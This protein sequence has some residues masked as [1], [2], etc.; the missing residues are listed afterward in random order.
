MN[1]QEKYKAGELVGRG[2]EWTDFTWNPI[3]GCKHACRWQMPDGKIAVCYAEE[4]AHGIAQSHYPDGFEAHYYHPKRLAEPLSLREPSKIFL[5]SMADLMGHW[6]P[7][8]QVRAVLDFC[9]RAH[10]HSFQLLTKNAPR[11]LQFDFPP[12]VW[13]GVSM[14]PSFMWGKELSQRQQE[15]KFRRDMEVLSQLR[16]PVRWVSFEPVAWDVAPILAEFPRVIN[17]AVIGAASSG[18][19]YYQPEKAHIQNLLDVL[20]SQ[21]VSVF[22][23]GNLEWSPWREEFPQQAGQL[24]LL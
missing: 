5:D 11:L 12:N 16:T 14:P 6:V 20:D 24:A 10:W 15:A 1:K 23:K 18:P 21:G 17:W 4:V 13:T 9:R 19:K 2:I 8:E 3:A 22:F 7:V